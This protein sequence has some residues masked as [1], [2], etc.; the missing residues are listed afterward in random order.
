MSRREL[1]AVGKRPVI[2]RRAGATCPGVADNPRYRTRVAIEYF[3]AKLKEKKRM[4][5][6]VDKLDVTYFALGCL[7]VLNLLC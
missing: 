6:R 5:S 3:F 2:L 4:A 7:N 1:L